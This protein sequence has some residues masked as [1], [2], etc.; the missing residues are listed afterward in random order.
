MVTMTRIFF[1]TNIWVR[2]YARDDIHQHNISVKLI[3]LLSQGTIKPFTSTVTLME[4]YF[5]STKVYSTPK[6]LVLH[7]LE[8]IMNLP[9]IY[10]VEET[11]FFK[12]FELHKKTN[13][14]LSDCIIASQLPKNTILCTFDKEFQRIK[15]I[16]AKTP[17]E[18]LKNIQ[19]EGKK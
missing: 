19:S 4:F 5:V 9:Y 1:D 18:I 6:K 14:K 2:F 8:E 10:I 11:D 16:T 3:N 12:A 15:S 13:V 17:G 7:Y